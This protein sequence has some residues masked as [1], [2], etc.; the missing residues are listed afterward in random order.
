[1]NSDRQF[2]S[3]VLYQ[4]TFLHFDPGSQRDDGPGARSLGPG[5]TAVRPCGGPVKDQ[6][7]PLVVFVS[8]LHVLR[9]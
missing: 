1:M 7:S 3:D 2:H 6:D 4:I 9:V 5:W 8:L